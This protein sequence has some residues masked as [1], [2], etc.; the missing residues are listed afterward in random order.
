MFVERKNTLL[1]NNLILFLRYMYKLKKSWAKQI[2]FTK[3]SNIIFMV[4]TL[5][6]G[7]VN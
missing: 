2:I 7:K 3:E 6:K 4:T 1:R 5:C